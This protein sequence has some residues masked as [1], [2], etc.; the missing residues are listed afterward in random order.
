LNELTDVRKE[1]QDKGKLKKFKDKEQKV[2]LIDSL[3]EAFDS[4]QKTRAP[5]ETNKDR[6][7][8]DLINLKITKK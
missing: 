6:I 5:T 1:F 8:K 4:E 2:E 7:I 3:K